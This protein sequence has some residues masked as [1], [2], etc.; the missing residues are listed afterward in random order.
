MRV[1]IRTVAGRQMT[2]RT[3]RSHTCRH[4]PYVRLAFHVVQQALTDA[5]ENMPVDIEDLK[6]WAYVAGLPQRALRRKLACA[7]RGQLTLQSA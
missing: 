5:A 6:P 1:T 2:S 7:R 4:D 3:L